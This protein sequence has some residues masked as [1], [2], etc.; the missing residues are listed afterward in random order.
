MKHRVVF[1]PEAVEQLATLYH[2]IAGA[3]SPEI[4]AR[5]TDAIVSCCESLST[6]P[7]RGVQR[8]DVR[9]GLRITNYKKRSV[10]AFD[11][12]EEQVSIVGVFYGG[13]DYESVLQDDDE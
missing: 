6:F 11:V 5:Y 7:H 10:I 12:T 9:L 8:D 4:A 3:S 1:S 2:H 13:Q